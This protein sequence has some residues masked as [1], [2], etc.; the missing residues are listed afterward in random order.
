MANQYTLGKGKLYFD[1]FDSNG[2]KT[3]ERPFGNCPEFTFTVASENLDHF[4]SE[5]GI[6]EKDMSVTLSVERTGSITTDNV[7][8]DNLAL[9]VIG[10]V[11]SVTQAA[12][13]VANEPIVVKKGRFYQ[14]GVSSGNPQGARNVSSV[15]VTN[16]AGTT[17]YVAG[18]DYNVDLVLGRLEIITTGAIANDA[19]LHVDYTPASNSRERVASS[20]LA[21]TEGALRF[22]SD[23]PVGPNRDL[24]APKVRLS[25]S[26]DFAWIGDDW[27][28]MQ[29]DIE[30]L[31]PATGSAIYVDGRAA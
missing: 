2:N 10:D 19:T 4:S 26:G 24:Y 23:N 16:T 27:L 29:L 17:T 31:K 28:S 1:P 12:T 7:S 5:S 20:S 14:L 6:A 21:A 18:T 9:F 22:I 8:A 13:P 25:P 3:G 30:F 11:S 15:V